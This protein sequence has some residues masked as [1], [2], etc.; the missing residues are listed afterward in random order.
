MTT[1]VVS[2][3]ASDTE[4]LGTASRPRMTAK[5]VGLAALFW[6]LHTVL[7]AL[8]IA[9]AVHI[10]FGWAATGQLI[11]NT[12]LAVYSVPVW[13]LA[14]RTMRGV[15]WGWVLATHVL[16]G[17]LYAWAGIES[18][19]GV[20]GL[21]AGGVPTALGSRYLWIFFS[22]LTLYIVQFALYHLVQ[23]VQRLRRK[24]QQAAELLARAREQ[25]LA[26]LKAQINPHFLFNTLNSIS[27]T[28]ARDPDQARE[29]IAKLAGMM[30]YALDSSSRDQVPLR[31]EVGFARKY[32]DLER[33]RFS[34]RLKA[35]VEVN[36][37]QKELDTPVPPMVLQPLVE[38][39]LRHGIAPSERGGTVQVEVGDVNDR[40]RI[41]VTDTGV[42]ADGV[43][44]LS[45]ESEGVGL[46]N[47]S[48]RLERTYGSD[49][50][51][52]TAPNDPSGF[53][54]WFSI[55]RDGK[56]SVQ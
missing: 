8:I 1:T 50:A 29:M 36:V 32:L 10:P 27:A 53:T 48:A 46:A 51:L 3:S 28:L 31:D 26:A 18:Y 39:A 49:A 56:A 38:N 4:L 20:Y 47:T 11:S 2:S 16:V 25:E 5:G 7:Y 35:Q 13:W 33:H 45:A 14:I 12:F 23:N 41:Q 30:R 17:P 22:N 44:P 19:F 43:D 9:Q 54:V 24:E 40:L 42:G 55:P 6:G 52:H 15:H 37:G 34:D 21:L